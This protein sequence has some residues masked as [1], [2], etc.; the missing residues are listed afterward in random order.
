M[1]PKWV[2]ITFTILI[3]TKK[4][5]R[6]YKGKKY[7]ANTI[8]GTIQKKYSL[9]I[10]DRVNTCC[11]VYEFMTGWGNSDHTIQRYLA[12]MCVSESKHFSD[13]CSGPQMRFYEV[14]TVKNDFIHHLD[15]IPYSNDLSAILS[16][17]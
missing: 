9:N 16:Q 11:I 1:T 15:T 2:Q 8:Y 7:Y 12:N 10:K 13:T 5:N 14:L 6:N 17:Y 3:N 4:R